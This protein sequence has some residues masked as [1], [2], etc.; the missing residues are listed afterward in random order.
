MISIPIITIAVVAQLCFLTFYYFAVFRP[1]KRNER[2]EKLRSSPFPD[3]WLNII[4]KQVPIYHNLPD[5]LK[6]QIQGHIQVFLDE[7]HFEGCGGLEINDAM[8]V[9]IAAQAC[10]LLLNRPTGYYPGLKTILVYPETYVAHIERTEDGL[11]LLDDESERWGESWRQ[12]MVVLAWDCVQKDIRNPNDGQNLVYHEFAHQLDEETGG[13]NGV[14]VL[15]NQV[16]YAE[17]E[18][19]F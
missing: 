18:K 11:I 4:Y 10:V 7:K 17:L 8:R 5:N 2:R 9:I 16:Q 12:G 1:Q 19:S 15:R 13:A 14:P 3:E 6:I